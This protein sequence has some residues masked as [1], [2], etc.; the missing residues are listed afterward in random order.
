MFLSILRIQPTQATR[1]TQR[2]QAIQDTTVR[3][4]TAQE[5]TTQAIMFQIHNRLTIQVTK[6]QAMETKDQVTVITATAHAGM[7]HAADVA[8]LS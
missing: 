6:A 3:D 1:L 4:I 7:A 8:K 2:T 5:I